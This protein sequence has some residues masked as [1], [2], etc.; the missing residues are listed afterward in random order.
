MTNT[1]THTHTHTHS[2]L[3]SLFSLRGKRM[4]V[5]KVSNHSKMDAGGAPDSWLVS[6]SERCTFPHRRDHAGACSAGASRS[7]EVL[8]GLRRWVLAGPSFALLIAPPPSLSLSPLP[9]LYF[10]SSSPAPAIWRQ[11]LNAGLLAKSKQLLR[12]PAHS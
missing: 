9:F 3:S 4:V 6:G 12:V 1:H 5:T 7:H 8:R 10:S 11:Q 2:T